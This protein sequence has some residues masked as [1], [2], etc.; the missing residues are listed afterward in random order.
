MYTNCRTPCFWNTVGVILPLVVEETVLF[1]PMG[2]NLLYPK[3]DQT[4]FTLL[5]ND[6]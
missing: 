6:Y 1:T 3:E 2:A 4:R 5:Q